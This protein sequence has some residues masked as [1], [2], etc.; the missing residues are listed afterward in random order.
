M[1]LSLQLVPSETRLLSEGGGGGIMLLP[2]ETIDFT[3]LYPSCLFTL[4]LILN[5]HTGAISNRSWRAPRAVTRTAAA[6]KEDGNKP[7]LFRVLNR[8]IALAF[9]TAT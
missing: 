7:L 5:E 4:H 3:R 2:K 9:Y 8:G 6:L 1:I